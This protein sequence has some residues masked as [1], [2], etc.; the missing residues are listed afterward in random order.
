M[1]ARKTPRTSRELLRSDLVASP[2][3]SEDSS[4]SAKSRPV[5]EP[6]LRL[7]RS[8][9]TTFPEQ[10]YA[11]L[12]PVVNKLLWTLLG[13]DPD[14][15]DLAHEIFLRILKNAGTLR[16]PSRLEAWAARVTVNA[17]KNEFRRRKL[18]RMFSFG[19]DAEHDSRG[20]HPDF[21]GRELLLRTYRALVSLPTSERVPFTL[22][23]VGQQSLE[24]IALGCGCSTRTIKRRLKSARARFMRL[25]L[26]DP[27][28]AERL[29]QASPPEVSD[30]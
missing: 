14:H 12:A 16:D 30:A 6:A 29:R 24:E 23:L 8:D 26:S 1:N 15:D 9:D 2:P 4:T 20:Y 11:T 5:G 3:R 25:A 18:L 21:E 19:Y 13:P 17:V 10:L 27:L 7:V 28:L 22:R